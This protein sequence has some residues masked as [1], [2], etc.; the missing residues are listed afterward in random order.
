MA[1][2][3]PKAILYP[4]IGVCLFAAYNQYEYFSAWLTYVENPVRH[5]N[6]AGVFLTGI[7]FSFGWIG[8]LVLVFWKKEMFS[9][10]DR[11]IAI[12]CASLVV[13]GTIISVVL[14]IAT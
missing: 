11:T 7:L 8:A 6:L 13:M 3:L 1:G 5:E 9:K 10:V 14:D 4:F 12:V 2:L